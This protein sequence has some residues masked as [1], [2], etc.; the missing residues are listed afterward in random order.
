MYIHYLCIYKN[1]LLGK[2]LNVYTIHLYIQIIK[3]QIIQNVYTL[4]L[5]IYKLLNYENTLMYI[6][7]S[8]VYTN[9]G[10]SNYSEYIYIIIMYLYIQIL[11][12]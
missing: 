2:H 3:F 5:C 9:H 10:I 1:R 7:Y 11:K 6:H 8:I 4:S 12:F